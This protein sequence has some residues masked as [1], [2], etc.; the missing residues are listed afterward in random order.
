MLILCSLI[1]QLAHGQNPLSN[2][3]P[4]VQGVAKM[5]QGAR[6]IREIVDELRPENKI[7]LAQEVANTGKKVSKLRKLAASL[8]LFGSFAAG[9]KIFGDLI[10]GSVE[11]ARHTELLR[12]FSK[13]ND[14]LTDLGRNVRRIGVEVE[15][16]VWK[17][18]FLDS[19]SG[20]NSVAS[21][22]LHYMELKEQNN[23]AIDLVEKQLRE[24]FINRQ[25]QNNVKEMDSDIND[26]AQAILD[27]SQGKCEELVVL[28]S[29][30]STTLHLPYQAYQAACIAT[31]K[32]NGDDQATAERHCKNLSQRLPSRKDLLD[33]IDGHIMSCRQKSS[34]VARI[35]T[36][37]EDNVHE[38][39]NY[40][41]TRDGLRHFIQETFPWMSFFV[42][43][44][45]EK[46]GGREHWV[47]RDIEKFRFKGRNIAILLME[48]RFISAEP[49]VEESYLLSRYESTPDC[50]TL[51]DSFRAQMRMYTTGLCGRGGCRGRKWQEWA[52]PGDIARKEGAKGVFKWVD[53]K[54][55]QLA[56]SSTYRRVMVLSRPLTK[57]IKRPAPGPAP[58]PYRTAWDLPYRTTCTFD[59]VTESLYDII[60]IY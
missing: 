41:T 50:S 35:D 15:E 18:S 2:S 13:L 57:R 46:H 53:T 28:K 56:P 9:A 23:G 22:Y 34:V 32:E 17:E 31:S 11:E 8:E 30:I 55:A 54:L 52:V 6:E 21:T 14:R 5:A 48:K 1:V 10:F 33:K 4:Y 60:V 36:W 47:H 51:T 19:I 25:V 43:V 37:L 3:D 40:D 29:F 45:D 49:S 26:Y 42:L 39:H 27:Y 59:S 58:L 20:L 24:T 7:A 16:A 38:N 12:E 44:Y